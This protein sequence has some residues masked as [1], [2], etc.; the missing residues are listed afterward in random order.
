MHTDRPV[1]DD[2]RMGGPEINRP[3]LLNR[4][5]PGKITHI[6]LLILTVHDSGEIK[7]FGTLVNIVS[8]YKYQRSLISKVMEFRK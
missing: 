8:Y 7:H 3:I 6:R 2:V 1:T 4:D 5:E